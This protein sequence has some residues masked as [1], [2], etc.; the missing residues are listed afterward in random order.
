DQSTDVNPVY[1]SLQLKLAEAEATL[2]G[3]QARREVLGAQ[4]KFHQQ[5]LMKLANDTTAFENLARTE[6]EAE[7]NYVLYTKKTEEARIAD[8]LDKQKIANVAIAE[9][10]IEPHVPSKP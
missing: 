6:K 9:A 1:Q 10:P 2:A 5:Q 7:E 4:L 8:S 3:A